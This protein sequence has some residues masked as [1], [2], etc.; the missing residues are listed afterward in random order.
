[1]QIRFAYSKYPDTNNSE[2][3]YVKGVATDEF[4]EV[5]HE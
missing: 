5:V 1:M 3:D 4:K 2:K